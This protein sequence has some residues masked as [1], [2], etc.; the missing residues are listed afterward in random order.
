MI[1]FK[2]IMKFL[3]LNKHQNG[4]LGSKVT[5]I[6]MNIFIYFFQV[7]LLLFIKENLVFKKR[8]LREI[9][10]L[11]QKWSKIIVQKK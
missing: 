4:I 11:A 6:L 3:N 2:D 5:A 10:I 9:A 1:F 7:M 8:F